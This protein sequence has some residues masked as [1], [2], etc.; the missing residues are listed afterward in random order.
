[1]LGV[2]R[3]QA[4]TLASHARGQL[5]RSLGAL[6]VARTGRRACPVLDML[7]DGWDGRLTALT[8]K[9]VSR[10]IGQC[11]VCADRRHGALRPAA[12]H[13][14]APLAALRTTCATRCCGCAPTPARWRSRTGRT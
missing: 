2:P 3:N 13:V 4:H 1:M 11:D 9:R 6:L 8:R 10:H 12:L 5:E 7:L 14:M